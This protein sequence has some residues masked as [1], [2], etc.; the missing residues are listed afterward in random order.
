M[1]DAT[2]YGRVQPSVAPLRSTGGTHVSTFG[3]AR[4]VR[5]VDLGASQRAMASAVREEPRPGVFLFAHHLEYGLIGRLWLAADDTPRAGTIGRHDAVDLALPL[6]D[7]LSLRHALFLVR[8]VKGQV[9]LT[10]LDLASSAGLVL[11]GPPL[12][13]LD[14]SGPLALEV[15]GFEVL[16]V[17]TGVPLPWDAQAEN[18]FATLRFATPSLTRLRARTPPKGRRLRAI[19]GRFSATL[20]DLRSERALL[21]DDLERGFLIGR[22]G[23]CDLRL[24]DGRVSRV[25]AALVRVDGELLLVDAGST[26]GLWRPGAEEVRCIAWRAGDPIELWGLGRLE[27]SDAH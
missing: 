10:V 24:P 17:P 15:S 16:C 11:G 23:R 22:H 3:S 21:E 6:D 25:H 27:W 19:A 26:N 7:A 8:A 13:R 18:P 20:G 9:R 5:E 12:R 14:V 1:N 2:R 4:R